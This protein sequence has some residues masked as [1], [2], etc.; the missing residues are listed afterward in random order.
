M[1]LEKDGGSVKVMATSDNTFYQPYVR[2]D[3][4]DLPWTFEKVYVINPDQGI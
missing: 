4:Y 3:F 2:I 1:T